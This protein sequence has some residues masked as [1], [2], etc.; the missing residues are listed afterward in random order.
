MADLKYPFPDI[1]AAGE[2]L[3]VADG[4]YWIR[5]PL[6]FGIDHINL[7]LL[8]DGDGWTIVDSGIRSAKL[9]EIWEGLFSG[10]MAGQP[11]KRLICTHHHPDHFGL[12]GWICERQN[13]MLWMARAEYF[14]GRSA[15]LDCQKLPPPEVMAYFRRAGIDAEG[16][17]EIEESRYDQLQQILIRPPSAYRRLRDEEELT[18]GG[19]LWRVVSGRGHSP[20]HICLLCEELGVLISGDQVLPRI[21]SNVSVGPTEPFANPLADWMTSLLRF[22]ELADDLLILP[23]HNEPFYG[24]HA[25]LDELTEG[26]KVRLERIEALCGEPITAAGIVPKLFRRKLEGMDFKLGLGECLAHLHYLVEAG[27]VSVEED[28]YGVRRFLKN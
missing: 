15:V 4:V 5:M 20:E 13:T 16:L 26:H 19:R 3:S 11:V 10:V 27:Q 14:T 23:A 2:A 1:P 24:L 21:S 8:A 6:P 18:I 9:Q 22:K 28:K 25:R 12:A 7:W 17:A